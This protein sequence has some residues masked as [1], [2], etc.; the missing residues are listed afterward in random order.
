MSN[1]LFGG[2]RN[3]LSMKRSGD[4]IPLKL[5]RNNV[6]TAKQAY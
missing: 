6:V 3:W 1:Q 5:W 4:D 2:G